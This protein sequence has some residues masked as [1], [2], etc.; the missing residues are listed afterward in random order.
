MLL[1]VCRS[2]EDWERRRTSER[3]QFRHISWI[4]MVQAKIPAKPSDE[5]PSENPRLLHQHIRMGGVCHD[6]SHP[7]QQV[8][9][10]EERVIQLTH[11]YFQY[12]IT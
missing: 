7:Q 12:Y 8:I 5:Y 1:Y 10:I 2:C 3:V 4:E 6:K 9:G 11:S